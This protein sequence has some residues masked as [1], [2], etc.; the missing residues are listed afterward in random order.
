MA[1]ISLNQMIEQLE[2]I[3]P[4]RLDFNVAEFTTE[5]GLYSK[6]SLKSHSIHKALTAMRGNRG[7]DGEND[8]IIPFCVI[9]EL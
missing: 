4:S 2:K 6:R 7:T 5:V 8:S 1:E 3:S 9:R